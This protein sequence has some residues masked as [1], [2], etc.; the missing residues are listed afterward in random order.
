MIPKIIH[1]CWFG[2][3]KMGEQTKEMMAT[4]KKYCPDYEIMIW[5]EDTFDVHNMGDYVKEAYLES[6]WA[7]VS[8]VAR[9]YALKEYGGIYMDTDVEVIKPL[10]PLLNHDA[11][12]GFEIETTISTALIAT[13]PHHPTFELLFADY[14]N[15]HFK[16]P[17]GTLDEKTNVNRI[18]EIFQENGLEL[19]NEYQEIMNVAIYPRVYFSPKSYWTREINDTKDTYAIHHYSGSWL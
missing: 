15:R 2:G 8:D 4:W 14:E 12:M 1:Y 3:N 17:D 9:L 18:T 6:K 16:N 13:V 10:D 11:F 7:F 5:N 19:N